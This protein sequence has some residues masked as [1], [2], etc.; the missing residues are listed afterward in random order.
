MCSVGDGAA[1]KRQPTNETRLESWQRL[2]DVKATEKKKEPRPPNRA[3]GMVGAAH[4]SALVG[5]NA[6]ASQ[7]SGQDAPEPASE[8]K[9][10]HRE[11]D[12]QSRQA[13][14]P[15]KVCVPPASV[16]RVPEICKPPFGFGG[17]SQVTYGQYGAN[18]SAAPPPPSTVDG[19]IV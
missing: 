17:W 2:A 10:K 3:A 6:C 14:P 15:G 11:A 9:D 18:N 19:E 8:S 1:G 13:R 4:W 16:Q 7:P 12:W 5:A